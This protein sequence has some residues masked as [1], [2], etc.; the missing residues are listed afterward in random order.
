MNKTFKIAVSI[1]LTALT[2][3]SMS[4]CSL[5]SN[6]RQSVEEQKNTTLADTPEEEELVNHFNSILENSIQNADKITEEVVYNFNDLSITDDNDEKAGL[7]GQ[8]ASMLRKLVAEKKPGKTSRE[9]TKDEIDDS[10]LISVEPEMLLDYEFSRNTRNVAVT[11]ENENELTDE[12][13]NEL[14]TVI[15]TDNI[16]HSVFKFFKD[17][18]DENGTT[19]EPAEGET[20]EEPT[21]RVYSDDE[22][23]KEIFGEAADKEEVLANFD[24]IKAYVEVIDYEI[25]NGD[26]QISSDVDL[27]E[28]DLSDIVF[29]QNLI[30]TAKIKGV[31]ELADY[32][33]MT[34]T[35]KIEK[36]TTYSFTFEQA[37]TEE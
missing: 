15:M 34:A 5:F 8:S 16:L 10:L 29:S 21:T 23:I 35:L 37:T 22:V 3:V 25:K 7:L 9:L 36:K 11:D 17:V 31:G 24:C 13:G 30:V 18:P 1:M 2:V 32:G 26:C 27:V 33:E 28:S 14:T 6:I 12:D 4:S 19:A 20:A